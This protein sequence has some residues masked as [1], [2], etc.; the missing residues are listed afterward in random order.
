MK[1]IIKIFP[2]NVM[3]HLN[4]YIIRYTMRAKYVNVSIP[5]ELAKKIDE[6][7]KKSKLGFRSRAEFLVEAA[8]K[9]LLQGK[10]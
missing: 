9:V 1:D 5:E 7:I 2:L 10:G 3:Y 8:R 4:I 6:F